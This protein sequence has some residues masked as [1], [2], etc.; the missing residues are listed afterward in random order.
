MKDQDQFTMGEETTP[1]TVNGVVM[2]EYK[3]SIPAALV[4]VARS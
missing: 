3:C 1:S 4:N 2:V